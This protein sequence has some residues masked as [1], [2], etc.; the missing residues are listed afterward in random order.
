MDNWFGFSLGVGVLVL[1]GLIVM[2]VGADKTILGMIGSGL[3]GFLGGMKV[4]NNGKDQ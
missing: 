2:Q 1:L 3:I 4:A